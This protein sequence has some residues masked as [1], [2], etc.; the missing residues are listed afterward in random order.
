MSDIPN[1][2][3]KEMKVN[4]ETTRFIEVQ[5]DKC[6]DV[7]YVKKNGSHKPVMIDD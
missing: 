6:G 5:C 1:C 2:C 7:I 4:I 3:G